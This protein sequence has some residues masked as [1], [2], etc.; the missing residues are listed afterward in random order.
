MPTV[1]NSIKFCQKC[2]HSHFFYT[3][4]SLSKCEKNECD[5]VDYE[6]SADG[7]NKFCVSKK[8]QAI[9]KKST[10]DCSLYSNFYTDNT[11]TVCSTDSCAGGTYRQLSATQKYCSTCVTT[12]GAADFFQDTNLKLCD[13]TCSSGH[14]ELQGVNQ[15]CVTSCFDS[16]YKD[17][18][19]TVKRCSI[20]RCSETSG[21][22][23]N[24]GTKVCDNCASAYFIDLTFTQCSKDACVTENT[25]GIFY[26]YD[27]SHKVCISQADCLANGDYYVTSFASKECSKTQCASTS[28]FYYKDAGSTGHKICV[29]DTSFYFDYAAKWCSNTACLDETTGG[30]SYYQLILG[31]KICTNCTSRFFEVG[32]GPVVVGSKCSSD[33][34]VAYSG[35]SY[36]ISGSDKL[37]DTCASVSYMFTDITLLICE[38]STC[39]ATSN[40]Y[41]FAPDNTRK[42]CYICD[43]SMDYLRGDVC[44][45]TI[46]D[47][48]ELPLFVASTSVN[49]CSL[50]A[51]LA[52]TTRFYYYRNGNPTDDKICTLCNGVQPTAAHKY[53]TDLICS[54]VECP[55]YKLQPQIA[56][57]APKLCSSSL[58]A[59]FYYLDTTTS[60]NVCD[61]CSGTYVAAYLYKYGYQCT[62]VACP[63][64]FNLAGRVCSLTSCAETA[65][66]YEF[67][68]TDKVCTTCTG[69]YLRD[70]VCSTT[71]CAFYK[72]TSAL[73]ADP[74]ICSTSSCSAETTGGTGYYK[75]SGAFKVCDNCSEN[76]F[77]SADV[78]NCITDSCTSET[79]S[80]M[81]KLEAVT[82]KR[83][84]TSSCSAA[85]DKFSMGIDVPIAG[86]FNCSITK[87]AGVGESGGKYTLDGSSN[88][89]CDNCTA[90]G[91]F[92]LG[93]VCSADSCTT[94]GIYFSASGS[95]VCS[96]ACAETGGK[97]IVVGSDKFCTQCTGAAEYL[98]GVVCSTTECN[99]FLSRSPNVCSSDNLCTGAGETAGIYYEDAQS[100]KICTLCNTVGWFLST[101]TLCVQQPCD[102]FA[103]AV[104]NTCATCAGGIYYISGTKKIC[105]TCAA[106]NEYLR[107]VICSNTACNFYNSVS[108]NVCSTT[109]CG[110]EQSGKYILSGGKYVC[111]SCAGNIFATSAKL[112]CVTDCTSYGGSYYLTGGASDDLGTIKI[113]TSCPNKYYITATT[114]CSITNC[115]YSGVVN[116]GVYKMHTDLVSRICDSCAGKFYTDISKKNCSIN[117]CAGSSET[118]GV[119]Y[120]DGATDK[121]C[122]SCPSNY[123]DDITTLICRDPCSIYYI[124]GVGKRICNATCDYYTSSSL[125]TCSTTTCSSE[126]SGIFYNDGTHKICTPCSGLYYIDI[127]TKE[128]SPD[129]CLATSGRK[130]VYHTDL[131]KKICSQCTAANEYLRTFECSTT[132]CEYFKQVWA[133]I[134]VPN[135]CS[136]DLCITETTTGFYIVQSG[137]TICSLCSSKY[138]EN[139]ITKQCSADSCTASSTGKYIKNSDFVTTGYMICTNC[140]TAGQYLTGLE[141]SLTPCADFYTQKS[142]NICAAD[143]TSTSNKYYFDGP[144]SGSGDKICTLCPQNHYEDDSTYLI[145]AEDNCVKKSS[146]VWILGQDGSSKICTDCSNKYLTGSQCFTTTCDAQS[147]YYVSTYVCSI[148]CATTNGYYYLTTPALLPSAQSGLKFCISCS[149][150]Y[151]YD[152]G[153]KIC[154]NTNC[155]T[156]SGGI[157]KIVGS[158]K[159]CTLCLPAD[160]YLYGLECKANRCIYF[161]TSGGNICSTTQCISDVGKGFYYIDGSSDK[162]C[163]NCVGNYFEDITNRICSLDN[164]VAKTSEIYINDTVDNTKKI[165]TKC[166]QSTEYLT[167]LQCS[168]IACPN[169]YISKLPNICS[170]DCS[171]ISSY[172]YYYPSTLICT[173][174]T[175]N[176]FVNNGQAT[177]VREKECSIDS[178][179][180]YSNG[181]YK[182]NSPTAGLPQMICDTCILSSDY[183]WGNECKDT[184]ANKCVYFNTVYS[185]GIIN[186]CSTTICID[187]VKNPYGYYNIES[188]NKI[189]NNCT[190][191]YFENTVGL[192]Q[193]SSDNCATYSSNKFQDITGKYVC[194]LC[195]QSNEYLR[196][197]NC[198]NTACDYYITVFI[199]GTDTNVCS[200]DSC[201]TTYSG[202][203]NVNSYGQKICSLSCSGSYYEDFA[204]KICSTDSCAAT[205]GGKYYDKGSGNKECT[206]CLLS[207]DYLRDLVCSAVACT[208]TSVGYYITKSPNVCS[209]VTTNPVSCEFTGYYEATAGGDRFCTSCPSKYYELYTTGATG[210]K[211]CSLDNCTTTSLN[212]Y[213]FDVTDTDKMICTQCDSGS[214]YLYQKLCS[215]V[216]CVYFA[217]IY[218]AS[219]QINTCSQNQCQT[220]TNGIF[221]NNASGKVCVP[222]SSNY[223]IDTVELLQC[224]LD[225]CAAQSNQY[226][227][228]NGK[229]VCSLCVGSDEYLRGS[230]CS[231]VKCDYF[232]TQQGIAS[233]TINQCSSDSCAAT[234]GFYYITAAGNKICDSCSSNYFEN[235]LQCSQ[236][237]CAT[238]SGGIY[239]ISG[240][241][242]ICT[243]CTG[244]S[245]YK[246]GLVCST[247][248]CETQAGPLKYYSTSPNVCSAAC[249]ETNG[250]Y[251]IS[252]GKSFCTSCP[253]MYFSDIA[254]KICILDNCSLDTSGIYQ[255][256]GSARICTPCTTIASE[257]LRNL[258]CSSTICNYFL[259]IGTAASIPNKCSLTNCINGTNPNGYY[260]TVSS[261]LLCDPC[262]NNYFYNSTTSLECSVDNCVATYSGIS[263]LVGTKQICTLCDVAGYYLQ[264]DAVSCSVIPCALYKDKSGSVKQCTA[265]CIN[266]P[267]LAI[268]PNG[269]FI[270]DAVGD[271]I[272]SSCQILG[273]DYFEDKAGLQCSSDACLITSNKIYYDPSHSV[274]SK[275]NQCTKCSGSS[276]YLYGLICKETACETSN[277]YIRKLPNICSIDC[278]AESGGK[279]YTDL[280]GHKV[281][282]NCS[283]NY[284]IS[285]L[286]CSIDKCITASGGKY[287]YDTSTPPK[288]ICS[289][290]NTELNYTR[291]LECTNQLCEYVSVVS[292]GAAIAHQCSLTQCLSETANAGYYYINQTLNTKVCTTCAAN[293]FFNTTNMLECVNTSAPA[294]SGT[295]GSTTFTGYYKMNAQNKMVCTL[296][297]ATDE[298]LLG[299]VCSSTRCQYFQQKNPNICVTSCVSGGNTAGYY[300]FD[301]SSDKICDACASTYAE[302]I[303]ETTVPKTKICSNDSCVS[304]SFGKYII[305]TDVV[306]SSPMKLC[307]NCTGNSEYLLSSVCSATDCETQS[308]FYQSKLPNICSNDDCLTYSNGYVRYGGSA[309]NYI[310]DSCL[311]GFFESYID[312]GAF[313]AGLKNCSIDNCLATSNGQYSIHT[314]AVT[315]IQIK[316]CDPCNAVNKFLRGKLCQTASPCDYYVTKYVAATSINNCS[317]TQCN[318]ETNNKGYYIM[319][320][321]VPTDKMCTNCSQNYYY[322]SAIVLQCLVDCTS[323][324]GRF[325]TNANNQRVCNLCDQSNQY[326]SGSSC[327]YTPCNYYKSQYV[328][329]SVIN[330]CSINACGAESVG[331]YKVLANGDKVC[332][333]CSSLSSYYEDFANKICS[334]DSCAAT[335]GGKYYDKGSGNKECT[336][337]LLSSDYL[338]DLVCSA[339]ACT[340][341]SVGYYI[342]KSPNV[343]STVT[344]NPVSCEFTGYYEATAG[345]DRFCTSCPSKYY[346]LYTTGATGEK[347]CSLDN[348]FATST[349]KFIYDVTDTDKMICTTCALA[350]QFLYG[351]ECSLTACAYFSKTFA[352]NGQNNC[353]LDQCRTET[354]NK[355]W[356]VTVSGDKVCSNCSQNYFFPLPTG[357]ECEPS[358]TP[359]STFTNGVTTG[360][361]SFDTQIPPRR[362]CSNCVL[363]LEYLRGTVC[364]STACEFYAQVYT[365][366]AVPNICSVDQCVTE[367]TGKYVITNSKKVCDACANNFFENATGMLQC[368]ADNCALTSGGKFRTIGGKKVCTMCTGSTEYLQTTLE[369]SDTICS[370]FLQKS[371][372]VCQAP[373]TTYIVDG[374]GDKICTANCQVSGTNYYTDITKTRCSADLCVSQTGGIYVESGADRIC[375]TCTQNNEYLT[376]IVCDAVPCSYYIKYFEVGSINICSS[377]NC[378]VESTNYYATV[379]I[380]VPSSTTIKVCSECLNGYFY[381]DTIILECSQ[382]SCTQTHNSIA[383]VN[384]IYFVQGGKK[385]CSTCTGA[386]EYLRDLICSLVAC[387]YYITKI[388]IG[389]ATQNSCSTTICSSTNGEYKVI[390]TYKICDLCSNFGNYYEKTLFVPPMIQCSTDNCLISSN[391]NYRLINGQKICTQCQGSTEYLHGNVC[392]DIKCLYFQTQTSKYPN[393]NV[394]AISDTCVDGTNTNGYWSYDASNDKYCDLCTN[395]Y[396]ENSANKQCSP[397]NCQVTSQQKYIDI[398][399][400]KNCVQCTLATQFLNSLTKECSTTKCSYFIQVNP[401]ICSVDC[402]EVTS[403][404]YSIFLFNAANEKIC[405]ACPNMYFEDV[406]TSPTLP[407][408]CSLD[409]CIT[410][411]NGV[412]ILESGGQKR[413]STCAIASYYIHSS[414][415]CNNIPCINE[416]VNKVF[417]TVGTISLC[418]SSCSSAL[419][420]IKP[421]GECTPSCTYYKII[422]GFKVCSLCDQIGEFRQFNGECNATVCSYYSDYANKICSDKCL[423]LAFAGIYT[424]S[425]GNKICDS[426]KCSTGKLQTSKEC[427][428]VPCA[429]YTISGTQES[430]SFDQCQTESLGIYIIKNATSKL[431]QPVAACSVSNY[432]HFNKECNSTPCINSVSEFKAFLV[433][434][435]ICI[436]TCPASQ[437][438]D[439]STGQCVAACSACATP[440][441]INSY[442][443]ITPKIQMCDVC[444]SP[445]F[446]H[447]NLECN[448]S[449]CSTEPI[450][451]YYD[452]V[453]LSCV[454]VC[455]SSKPYLENGICVSVCVSNAYTNTTAGL[456]NLRCV[457]QCQGYKVLNGTHYQCVSQ[458]AAPFDYIHVNGFECL[459]SCSFYQETASGLKQCISSCSYYEEVFENNIIIGKCV[460]YCVY[461]YFMS[462]SIYMCKQN[463][464]QTDRPYIDID[465]K[466]CVLSCSGNN[467]ISAGGSKCDSGC[468][469]TIQG[470]QKICIQTN[471]LCPDDNSFMVPFSQNRFQCID[472]CKNSVNTFVDGSNLQICVQCL[473]TQYY[474]IDSIR[475]VSSNLCFTTCPIAK[476]YVDQT[477]TA[478]S[479]TLQ[480][481]EFCPISTFLDIDNNCKTVCQSSS[482]IIGAQQNLCMPAPCQS[483]YYKIGAQK[484]CVAACLNYIQ[485]MECIDSILNCNTLYYEV[486]G[487]NKMSSN[488]CSVYIQQADTSK[489]CI[490]ICN[491]YLDVQ[492][493]VPICNQGNN[494]ISSDNTLCKVQCAANEAISFNKLSCDSTCW[495]VTILGIKYCTEKQLICPENYPFKRSIT[496]LEVFECVAFCGGSITDNSFVDS[497]DTTLCTSCSPG[498][499][500]IPKTV[501]NTIAYICYETCPL[502]YPYQDVL[503]QKDGCSLCVVSCPLAQKYSETKICVP[504]CS[505]QAYI[506][507]ANVQQYICTQIPCQSFYRLGDDSQKICMTGCSGAF[508]K[509]NGLQCQS[510]CS[511]T[512]LQNPLDPTCVSTCT[513]Y[514]VELGIKYCVK[515]CPVSYPFVYQIAAGDN[516]CQKSCVSPAQYIDIDGYTCIASCDYLSSFRVY[517]S[518]LLRCDSNCNFYNN[519]TQ[520][521]CVNECPNNLQYKQII[522]NNRYECV[523]SCP[524]GVVNNSLTCSSIVCTTFLL[525]EQSNGISAIKCVPYCPPG[526]F[527][528]LTVGSA[529]QCVYSCD[530][531]QKYVENGICTSVCTI[532]LSGQQAYIIN[533]SSQQQL[534]CVQQCPNY[535]IIDST[536]FLCVDNCL[537]PYIYIS[538]KRCMQLSEAL[539]DCQ[540]YTDI[541]DSITH[542]TTVKICNTP[543]DFFITINGL[544]KCLKQC[545]DIQ[546]YNNAGSCIQFCQDQPINK[547]LEVDNI[548]CVP[549]CGINS[550]NSNYRC[551]A[552]CWFTNELPGPIKTCVQVPLK[553]PGSKPFRVQQGQTFECVS[554]CPNFFVNNKIEL[555]CQ[556]CSGFYQQILVGTLTAYECLVGCSVNMYIDIDASVL[557]QSLGQCVSQCPASRSYIQNQQCVA[558]T[559]SYFML[560][561]IKICNATCASYYIGSGPQQ[562]VDSCIKP[563]NYIDGLECKLLCPNQYIQFNGYFKCVV[564]CPDVQQDLLLNTKPICLSSCASVSEIG[565]ASHVCSLDCPISTYLSHDKLSCVP[566]CTNLD[567]ISADT[568]YCDRQCWF[569]LADPTDPNSQKTCVV[570]Y[571]CPANKPIQQQFSLGRYECVSTCLT[572][573][574]NQSLICDLCPINSGYIERNINGLTFNMCYQ[575]CPGTMILDKTQQYLST[576]VYK[577]VYVCTQFVENGECVSLC[578]NGKYQIVNNQKICVDTCSMYYLDEVTVQQCVST[579]PNFIE[580]SKCVDTCTQLFYQDNICVS[581]CDF[582][583]LK[584]NGMKQC[585]TECSVYVFNTQCVT[586]C[587]DTPKPFIDIDNKTCV[588]TCQSILDN[589]Y[590]S[591]ICTY[592]PGT[593]NICVERCPPSDPFMIDIGGRYSCNTAC[594]VN[595]FIKSFISLICLQNC[596]QTAVGR[597]QITVDSVIMNVCMLKCPIDKQYL[598]STNL[599]QNVPLCVDKCTDYADDNNICVTNCP[600]NYAITLDGIHCSQDCYYITVSRLISSVATNFRYCVGQQSCPNFKQYLGN[601]KYECVEKCPMFSDETH[602]CITTCNTG[603]QG[604]SYV[605]IQNIYHKICFDRCPANSSYLV[606]IEGQIELQ[607][608]QDCE[609]LHL[610]VNSAGTHCVTQCQATETVCDIFCQ[611][612]CTHC[613]KKQYNNSGVCTQHCPD[614]GNFFT[615]QCVDQC[616]HLNDQDV[617]VLTCPANRTL[618]AGIC[619]ENVQCELDPY[620]FCSEEHPFQ[621]TTVKTKLNTT[622]AGIMALLIILIIILTICLIAICKYVHKRPQP[623]NNDFFVNDMNGMWENVINRASVPPGHPGNLPIIGGKKNIER[624]EL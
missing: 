529:K 208:V 91:K 74:K 396:F 84:C 28:G 510:S 542:L 107:G 48:F 192:L 37:C 435:K 338:R 373:C 563:Y 468:N 337:C 348:C 190:N 407:K 111:D 558:C 128:C 249:A 32:A 267:S 332:V 452:D 342:T 165:C 548:T 498:S 94:Q 223:F 427:S 123:Y 266:I 478:I 371:P 307:T 93:A 358:G 149:A 375:T 35:G 220:E 162:I 441:A 589:K 13:T 482:Y 139:L 605:L 321:T 385:I 410:T 197:S 341:T 574:V 140:T 160:G 132:V 99:F 357:L 314:D 588:L 150:G 47:Y 81:Y 618:Y 433:S 100:K 367:Q 383:Y 71:A 499:G 195:D 12:L 67:S 167:G 402:T 541:D 431:C 161:V 448:T 65:G 369:C 571:K 95:N 156:E 610:L 608:V 413:C 153:A 417:D 405:N 154:S 376:G 566:S 419:S 624:I 600:L 512:D 552:E 46:C 228:I 58:C 152:Y 158:V 45:S 359:C 196:G 347:K 145:C 288:M 406:P 308:K 191:N 572:A 248:A 479:G 268:N 133:S 261:N 134:A 83:I 549:D 233:A 444:S 50:D 33:A 619:L 520:K 582:Y 174:C 103:N 214:T 148:D 147:L 425:G 511:Y 77:A 465:N 502:S 460:P 374:A 9:D 583:E 379:S 241:K 325:I 205:S 388:G 422:G 16:F 411:S 273:T 237:N 254:Q 101:A 559:S 311:N 126:S 594:P 429:Y 486:Q 401:N 235:S 613:G 459:Q 362:M 593:P 298:F 393:P 244:A 609:Q 53:L 370:F 409:M 264:S 177:S 236:N 463:C 611:A 275:Q 473:S 229:M 38:V 129:N 263:M 392:N 166:Q 368:S 217:Q 231:N 317:V 302:K 528:G 569:V 508:S 564:T 310:C 201:I 253:N 232:L 163:T 475:G 491:N 24:Y 590:C 622:Q 78:Q 55:Y 507:Q 141:C 621:P 339:V 316:V 461:Q 504:I 69:K 440:I 550:I 21:T 96:S 117:S 66:I 578:T 170:V 284:Y 521:V 238:T 116:S 89:I 6:Y 130:Y 539:T 272:C 184:I 226:K 351:L 331:E 183:L 312:S 85:A 180:S 239:I 44:S 573:F 114:E 90:A 159:I 202:K 105:T 20:N 556:S 391:N 97:Y 11:F 8:K 340:V 68:G 602:T 27:G 1:I 271:K 525:Q 540:Y 299:N 225:A 447:S 176:Y 51:C 617:C 109:N 567:A 206:K 412:Y 353:S 43:Q 454:S 260:K 73:T 293:Y 211:K 243:L 76:F 227:L 274:T 215:T 378:G 386:S 551:D 199:L 398:S 270:I 330:E 345:G 52:S 537:T 63:F 466:T 144:T 404:Y 536:Y 426:T 403:G 49:K 494:F 606:P 278:I 57:A 488:T 438:V 467:A 472:D 389:A 327:S 428:S 172:G 186:N 281:C 547:Y 286:E 390:S 279:Y 277:Y 612:D 282:T 399:G 446:V 505:Q 188:G 115:T 603:L 384:G 29:S 568:K 56:G 62:T 372:N 592:I 364:S 168:L 14:Y 579:C 421:T 477:S 495:F 257:Y 366:A 194:T 344:T 204:N 439:P 171:E 219:S 178:C 193:C 561:G 262:T 125:T 151:Y 462:V 458:C 517:S 500:Y 381:N 242:K 240:V 303:D 187:A 290:C 604:Y 292:T 615:H 509:Q 54:T 480:C 212:V 532:G 137:K 88:K 616:E 306:T 471:T 251:Y 181:I 596:D 565:T 213:I 363:A 380:T 527:A 585:V 360:I 291:G 492:Q 301:S 397:D 210:E 182:F 335:S 26:Q 110:A 349:R 102:Y 519:G 146:G 59:G 121:I 557:Y 336:K 7:V 122:T 118:G 324:S 70:V 25:D 296:C 234:T 280:A 169:Y 143:C 352:A 598:D 189:C 474:T 501:V 350:T 451:K 255:V 355:G 524:N 155:A 179:S 457:S 443:Q 127:N 354:N 377:S 313:T 423:E 607:C 420:Y 543:C 304:S 120:V 334:T 623:V 395:A 489:Q 490:Q 124:N 265:N 620:G 22:Y 185:A 445:K 418:K 36:T 464:S 346:E 245:E 469:F 4:S 250:V 523:S 424:V 221:L 576:Q 108:P 34:C 318:A 75:Y 481:V 526:M 581:L 198:S 315:S 497:I 591:N 86:S 104:D 283:D 514:Y 294:C 584:Q 599:Y 432:T 382:D 64:Y 485:D 164:C 40:R 416:A 222:C 530:I 545:S 586:S 322:D 230:I 487:F 138:F 553:C 534:Y 562:C 218:V 361:Y 5:D 518:D 506:L 343:C 15:V 72:S 297:S 533:T 560:S 554:S 496:G 400:L 2:A 173:T 203:F 614:Y 356:F 531:S 157:Y 287:T 98:T 61:T 430:C 82:G 449:L 295:V 305:Q 136:V 365:S 10:L 18:T 319:D 328:A 394:C 570:N 31:K 415:E 546:D 453:L 595:Y 92:L 434:D 515:V 285:T 323:T 408:E 39:S 200:L 601:N 516:R 209:T 42:Y 503:T 119:Y 41:Q 493:C 450:N 246:F 436:N 216:Q 131:T 470:V 224:S 60:K 544:K 207:S 256:A 387:D 442:I 476:S 112:F 259:I 252:G 113:C 30:L 535:Y 142:P 80:K 333:A 175:Q 555:I 106:A 575:K 538:N 17:N 326:L 456:Q 79:D 522:I 289:S 19:S 309:D 577:C 484:L 455:P 587:A 414:K 3:D 276:E 135:I 23:V 300:S 320:T 513:L 87:C 437:F 483:Y 269:Y 580:N 329:G 247:D 597:V 258:E